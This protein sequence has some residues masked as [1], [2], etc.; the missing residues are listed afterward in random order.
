[1]KNR[2]NHLL[3]PRGG[4]RTSIVRG[5]G[6]VCGEE[7]EVKKSRRWNSRITFDV[8]TTERDHVTSRFFASIDFLGNQPAVGLS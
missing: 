7:M 6:V 4:L 2:T 3:L 1:M 5:D 8:R